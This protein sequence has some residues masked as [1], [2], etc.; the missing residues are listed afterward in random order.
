MSTTAQCTSL[1]LVCGHATYLRPA[2]PSAVNPSD[3]S[4]WLLAPFQKSKT[5]N[6][7][8][9]EHETF[10]QH[11]LTGCR[12]L[13]SDPKAL[14]V[15]SGGRTRAGCDVSEAR[16]YW[17]V[18]RAE[19]EAG[20]DQ[21]VKG[22]IFLE[23]NATDSFQNL[24]FSILEFRRV[25][26]AYPA[27]VTVVTH[28][29]KA[30]RFCQLHAVAI[31]WPL[32]RL[33]V[34]GINPPFTGEELREVEQGERERGMVPFE[35]DPYGAGALLGGKRRERCW[36]EEV[37]DRVGQGVEQEI[38]DLLHWKGGESEREMFAGNLPWEEP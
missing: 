15:F 12:A 28:A 32:G 34:W 16:G 7:K 20:M 27:T 23:E 30:E 19:E 4:Q 26:G 24:L 17:D 37:L 11:I 9:S 25:V 21:G 22:R 6:S 18:L 1:I 2:N 38:V 8:P 35:K 36:S 5:L 13:R 3:E 29:F 10:I 14:L 33:R 31:K